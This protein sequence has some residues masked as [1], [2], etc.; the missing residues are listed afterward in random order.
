MRKYGKRTM[1]ISFLYWVG[2]LETVGS[3]FYHFSKQIFLTLKDKKFG[4]FHNNLIYCCS[5]QMVTLKT[6]IVLKK[7]AQCR[8]FI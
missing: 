5:C 4:F 6:N 3:H 1:Q 2:F 7:S 8:K